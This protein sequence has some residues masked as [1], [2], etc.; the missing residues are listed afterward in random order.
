M[1]LAFYQLK[2]EKRE[3]VGVLGIRGGQAVQISGGNSLAWVLEQG[4][5]YFGPNG[6]EPTNSLDGDKYLLA[7]QQTFERGAYFNCDQAKED[8]DFPMED[9]EFNSPPED[10]AHSGSDSGPKATDP[11]TSVRDEDDAGRSTIAETRTDPDE[12]QVAKLRSRLAKVN[13]K[14]CLEG[15]NLHFEPFTWVDVA[16]FEALLS[17]TRNAWQLTSKHRQLDGTMLRDSAFYLWYDIYQ[18]ISGASWRATQDGL[19]SVSVRTNVMKELFWLVVESS[20]FAVRDGGDLSKR[21]FEALGNLLLAFPQ[22]I[23]NNISSLEEIA[24][25]FQHRHNFIRHVVERVNQVRGESSSQ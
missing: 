8:W 10:D 13:K 5:M 22:Q 19:L 18:S 3:R 16:G 14:Y 7:C 11:T 2:N 1:R 9:D 12:I 25:L 15:Q 17:I 6:P 20:E 23:D 21:C 4:Q 24:R